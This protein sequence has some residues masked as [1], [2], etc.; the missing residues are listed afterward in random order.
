MIGFFKGRKQEEPIDIHNRFN[1]IDE[2]ENQK[3]DLSS[4]DFEA[5]LTEIKSVHPFLKSEDGSGSFSHCTTI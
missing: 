3:L 1:W 5:R 4:Q 2:L